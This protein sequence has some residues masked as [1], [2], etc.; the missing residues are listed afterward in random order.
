[1][2]R[3][4][5]FTV[6][7]QEAVQRAQELAQARQHQ[8]LDGMHL[9]AALLEQRDGVVPDLIERLGGNPEAIAAAADAELEKHP[10]VS[11]DAAL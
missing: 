5:R 1:M 4:D 3:L 6:R 9:L 11:G 2:I 7:A 10:R 8:R